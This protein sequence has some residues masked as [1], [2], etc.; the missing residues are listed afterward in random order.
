MVMILNRHRNILVSKGEY[1]GNTA[2]AAAL[3]LGAS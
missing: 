3:R 2:G 1:F